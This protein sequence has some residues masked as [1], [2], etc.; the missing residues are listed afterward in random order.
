[1]RERDSVIVLGSF[2]NGAWSTMVDAM[3][4]LSNSGMNVVSP[5]DTRLTKIAVN[6]GDFVYL[7]TD[8]ERVGLIESDLFG[9]SETAIAVKVGFLPL[10][11]NVLKS[12]L[13]ENPHC[14]VYLT[15]HHSTLGS[16]TTYESII[17]GVANRKMALS[18]PVEE[19]S[20]KVP[21]ELRDFMLDL[22]LP[23]IPIV[24]FDKLRQHPD[25]VS[26]FTHP[27]INIPSGQAYRLFRTSVRSLLRRD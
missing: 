13:R 21:T 9:L 6:D 26:E 18:S 3:H 5:C 22:L 10:Q 24:S 14:C 7:Q 17:A 23:Q 1:M 27:N 16:S 8:L 4:I 25:V 2:K 19:I 12:I 11:R 20:H 15:N